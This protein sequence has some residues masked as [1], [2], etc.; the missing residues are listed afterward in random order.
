[1]GDDA[2]EEDPDEFL[3]GWAERD[4]AETT[5]TQYR[6][7]LKGGLKA[8]V[9]TLPPSGAD[10]KSYMA[11]AVRNYDRPDKHLNAVKWWC[12]VNGQNW[13]VQEGMLEAA[14][15][16]KVKTSRRKN[17]ATPKRSQR[18]TAYRPVTWND[19]CE[20]LDKF[21]DDGSPEWALKAAVITTGWRTLC[22]GADMTS[23]AV[24]E[25]IIED[26]RMTVLKR[27]HK[28]ATKGDHTVR[29]EVEAVAE[30]RWCP[31][32]M[33]RRWLERRSGVVPAEDD[34][35]FWSRGGRKNARVWKPMTT[36]NVTNMVK[37]LAREV[38]GTDIGFGAHSLRKGGAA[39][40][41]AAGR[42]R[43]EVAAIGGWKTDAAMARYLVG[44]DD[45]VGETSRAMLAGRE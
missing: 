2:V 10:V 13:P 39:A 15:K 33:M 19:I 43:M 38:R 22:R 12:K 34:L 6:Q 20:Y 4:L 26:D 8:G 35:L 30:A 32:D 24:Q 1:M 5:V 31:V 41:V 11:W 7:S 29:I 28:T 18:G 23:L 17:R 14:V 3:K 36:R 45:R 25:I 42:P 44:E 27:F 16:A 37:H 40:L 21:P 9:L